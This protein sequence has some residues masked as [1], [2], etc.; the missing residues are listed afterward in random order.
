M[1]SGWPMPMPNRK[2]SGCRAAM[3]RYAAAMS[4]GSL[5]HMLTIAVATVIVV[6]RVE[7]ALD[8]REVADRRRGRTRARRWGSRALRLG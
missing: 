5:V 4:V 3:R 8:E 6:G 1:D 2:R 7:D